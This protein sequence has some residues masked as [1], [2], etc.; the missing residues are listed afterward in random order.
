MLLCHSNKQK[1]KVHEG[2]DCRQN[3]WQRSLECNKSCPFN[4]NCTQDRI[5]TQDTVSGTGRSS[6]EA[7]MKLIPRKFDMHP[8]HGVSSSSKWHDSLSLFLNPWQIRHEGVHMTFW[9]HR[10]GEKDDD[11][12]PYKC[13]EHVLRHRINLSLNHCQDQED[14]LGMSSSCL[15]FA[16]SFSLTTEGLLPKMIRKG[17]DD[18]DDEEDFRGR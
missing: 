3:R 2:N 11:D 17:K 9:Q 10:H 14:S 8:T 7:G 6:S 15:L 12:Y 5:H 16:S 13:L 1:L 4:V 18:E